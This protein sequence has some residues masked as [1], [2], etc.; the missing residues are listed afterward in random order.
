MKLPPIADG[1]KYRNPQSESTHRKGDL[2]TLNSNWDV[3]IKS[4]PSGLREPAEE[5]ESQG[6][7]ENTKKTRPSKVTLTKLIGAQRV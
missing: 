2:A 1:D 4:T 3:S 6:G 5:C 7:M